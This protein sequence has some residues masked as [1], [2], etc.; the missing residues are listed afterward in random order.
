LEH[1]FHIEEV[2][3]IDE[4]RLFLGFSEDLQRTE[5]LFNLLNG[6]VDSFYPWHPW[7]KLSLVNRQQIFF[8]DGSPREARM[9]SDA[10][11]L[12]LKA[13][14]MLWSFERTFHSSRHKMS[15]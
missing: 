9:C 6:I 10:L 5:D 12:M 14:K 8:K 2:P 3:Q 1:N 11:D 7:S 13:I 4:E 15:R